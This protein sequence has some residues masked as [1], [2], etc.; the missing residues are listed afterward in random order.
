[1][2]KKL[3][4]TSIFDVV[5]K[6]ERLPLREPILPYD[7][8]IPQ[9]K[10]NGELMIYVLYDKKDVEKYGF[11]KERMNKDVFLRS[12]VYSG[13]WKIGVL[14]KFKTPLYWASGK[15]KVNN[16]SVIVV[17]TKERLE[18]HGFDA[19]LITKHVKKS[20]RDITVEAPA[21]TPTPTPSESVEVEAPA[22]ELK[23]T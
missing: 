5:E 15:H 17:S 11:K 20:K 10:E 22:K 7:A 13:L 16:C 14:G 18:E 4:E 23:I 3:E 1:M 12:T 19:R 9:L 21:P 6:V 2:S 8:W